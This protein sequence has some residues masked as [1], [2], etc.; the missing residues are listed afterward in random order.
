VAKQPILFQLKGPSPALE[1][2]THLNRNKLSIPPIK[3]F[4]KD[5]IPLA[6]SKVKHREIQ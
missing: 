5:R 4:I 3:P 1:A 6:H 2:T